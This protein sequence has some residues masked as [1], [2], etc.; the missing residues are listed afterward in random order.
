[1]QISII[2]AS[3]TNS[4][5]YTITNVFSTNLGTYFVSISNIYSSSTSAPVTLSFGAQPAIISQPASV[6][7][8][9]GSIVNFNVTASGNPAPSYQ[10]QFNGT[11]LGG[12]TGTS[13]TLSNVQTNNNGSYTVVVSN[14]VASIT[15]APAILIVSGS[16]G[17]EPATITLQPVSQI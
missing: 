6:T 15:S 3:P 10:W 5:V 9:A 16:A 13:F 17:P 2:G 4:D 14:S 12:A 11:N 1:R 7:T 8:N